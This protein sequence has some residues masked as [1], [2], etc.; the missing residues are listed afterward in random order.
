MNTR[1]Q[2]LRPLLI[3]VLGVLV[4]A[5][6]GMYLNGR[7]IAWGTR[8]W[9]TQLLVVALAEALAFFGLRSFREKE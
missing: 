9:F 5:A 8:P 2:S 1:N 3:A 4:L 7:G 6:I